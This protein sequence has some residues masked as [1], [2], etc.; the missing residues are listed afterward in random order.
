VAGRA[1]VA[2]EL[3]RAEVMIG[4]IVLF[5]EGRP[6]DEAAPEAANYLKNDELTVE[7]LSRRGQRVVNGVDLRF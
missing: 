4:P 2:F 5:K 3:D 6:Y 7:R 1:G